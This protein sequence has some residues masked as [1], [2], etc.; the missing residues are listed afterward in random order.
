MCARMKCNQ[1]ANQAA[2]ASVDTVNSPCL[3]SLGFISANTHDGDDDG[4]DGDRDQEDNQD[5]PLGFCN[6]KKNQKKKKEFDVRN[7]DCVHETNKRSSGL[8]G[9]YPGLQTV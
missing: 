7:T 3:D 4:E 8:S 1:S 6:G 9:L 2:P 5:D